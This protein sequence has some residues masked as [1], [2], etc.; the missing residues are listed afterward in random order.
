MREKQANKRI[1]LW[2]YMF[3]S[4]DKIVKS[5]V[6][7]FNYKISMVV[8]FCGLSLCAIPTIAAI[9]YSLRDIFVMIL[10]KE[11]SITDFKTANPN[12]AIIGIIIEVIICFLFSVY[13]QFRKDEILSITAKYGE[14]SEVLRSKKHA[15]KS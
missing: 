6:F 7:K 3:S 8:A 12:I 10:T 2:R 1:T 15:N 9:L 13:Y 14:R 4:M 5:P 11:P